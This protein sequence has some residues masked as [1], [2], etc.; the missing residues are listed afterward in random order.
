[1]KLENSTFP[2]SNARVSV[3][4]ISLAL[5]A[6]ASGY[7]MSLI[8]LMLPLKGMDESL[9]SMLA[10][11]FYAGLLLGAL[12]VEPVIKRF[13]HKGV[14]LLCL[15][16]FALTTLCIS[17]YT[18]SFIWLTSRFIAGIS[19]AGIFVTVESWLIHGAENARAKRLSLYMASL[20]GG[21]AL[22]QSGIGL[23]GV[24]GH[25]PFIAIVSLLIGSILILIF[26]Q[27]DQPASEDSYSITFTQLKRLN[28]SAIIG[29]MV[30]GLTM[31][32][33]YGLMPLEL[34]SLGISN[35]DIS[36][37]M[38]AV[39]LGGMSIQPILP[40]MSKALSHTLLMALFALL[41]VTAIAIATLIGT[42]GALACALF[43]LGVS[44]FALYPVAINLGCKGL[45]K[46]YIVSATQVML[47]SY[48]LGSV[49]GPIMAEQFNHDSEGVMQYLFI[50]LLTTCVYMIIH[51]VKNMKAAITKA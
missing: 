48:S 20:Y 42:T 51:S 6:I 25:V 29:C 45:D 15:S 28:H 50:T 18:D 9:A 16:T 49:M 23:I 37:L 31:S 21:S 14:F 24:S 17:L 3:P 32:A 33:I 5:Y 8:P 38:A 10:S 34:Q 12:G 1:M 13:G 11:I 43:L 2:H 47:I 4:V 35:T 22:G 44:T 19:V 30:S 27:S 26:G 41:G 7:L 39:I 36:G 46:E 40:W